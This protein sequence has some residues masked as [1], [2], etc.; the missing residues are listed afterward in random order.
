MPLAA[1]PPP[2]WSSRSEAVDGGDGLGTRP[3]CLLRQVVPYAAGDGPM[4]VLAGEL[5]PVA[6]RLRMGRTI[7]VTFEGD[8]GH[9]DDGAASELLFQIVVLHLALGHSEPPAIVVD[10]NAD[11]IWVVKGRGTP[12]ERLVA[13]SPL[14]RGGVPDEVGKLAPVFAVAG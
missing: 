6:V 9:G 11:M 4:R 3:R 14:G 10:H 1:R 12:A 13:E 8:R 7:G 5:R 2:A